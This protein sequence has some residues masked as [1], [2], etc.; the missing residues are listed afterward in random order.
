M[1][2]GG[3]GFKRSWS[4]VER[5]QPTWSGRSGRGQVRLAGPRPGRAGEAGDSPCHRPRTLGSA[6]CA[7]CGTSPAWAQEIETGQGMRAGPRAPGEPRHCPQSPASTYASLG[8]PWLRSKT[9]RGFRYQRKDWMIF[10]PCGGPGAKRD[11]G[12]A[13][14]GGRLRWGEAQGEGC[15]NQAQ[16]QARAGDRIRFS[17]GSLGETNGAEA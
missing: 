6:G 3:G 9:C 14:R 1:A 12:E 15:G 8:P 17:S 11:R 13:V 10:A 2:T 16:Q 7:L 4:R 5:I